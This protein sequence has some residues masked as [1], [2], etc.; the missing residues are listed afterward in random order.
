MY[1]ASIPIMDKTQG[2]TAKR[3]GRVLSGTPGAKLRIRFMPI[4]QQ[5]N[6]LG[7]AKM[8]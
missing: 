1:T 7:A 3:K 6:Y 8:L 2:M 4:N 5:L